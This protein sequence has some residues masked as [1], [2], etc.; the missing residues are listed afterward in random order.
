M[1]IYI[2]Q[3]G[4]FGQYKNFFVKYM[5]MKSN[6]RWLNQGNLKLKEH[7]LQYYL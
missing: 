1:Y 2:K 4:P 7:Y 3:V 6:S 5:H